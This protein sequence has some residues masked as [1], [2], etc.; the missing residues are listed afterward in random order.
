M[1]ACVNSMCRLQEGCLSPEF[2][3]RL[4][5]SRQV[6]R[7]LRLMVRI[8]IPNLFTDVTL[9]F[10]RT[11]PAPTAHLEQFATLRRAAAFAPKAV[12][13]RDSRC[14]AATGRRTTTNASWTWKPALISWIW[15]SWP[16]ENA[17]STPN[18]SQT[19]LCAA[20]NWIEI[21]FYI[22][23]QFLNLN[24]IWSEVANRMQNLNGFPMWGSKVN[25]MIFMLSFFKVIIEFLMKTYFV[26]HDGK[27]LHRSPVLQ[28]QP[29]GADKRETW[30]LSL[31]IRQTVKWILVQILK[32]HPVASSIQIPTSWIE[33]NPILN[34]WSLRNPEINQAI[35]FIHVHASCLSSIVSDACNHAI[36]LLV[37]TQE[38]VLALFHRKTQF[39]SSWFTNLCECVQRKYIFLVSFCLYLNVPV[40]WFVYVIRNLWQHCV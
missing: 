33:R 12:W 24:S 40:L 22:L 8:C 30:S 17:V 26:D 39:C 4:E 32:K 3:W 14:A 13:R 21:A 18:A 6:D 11:S 34:F 28:N 15:K 1:Q 19:G 38:T 31:H 9:S 10:Q 20:Q 7:Q 27:T 25:P 2:S 35:I 5:R 23:I 37:S 36:C 29:N 16:M